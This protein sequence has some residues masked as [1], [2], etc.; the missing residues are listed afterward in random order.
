MSGRLK[1][2]AAGRDRHPRPLSPLG[3][4][5]DVLNAGELAT[6]FHLPTAALA[7]Q[8]GLACWQRVQLFAAPRRECSCP[9]DPPRP[10]GW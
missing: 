2:I 10:S 8:P 6:I 3:R 1:G 7:R 9:R 4:R 5:L